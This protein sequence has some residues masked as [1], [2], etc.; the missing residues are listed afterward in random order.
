MPFCLDLVRA[1]SAEHRPQNIPCVK[2]PE[3]FSVSLGT[4]LV[5]HGGKVLEDTNLC[6]FRLSCGLR[7]AEDKVGRLSSSLGLALCQEMR[8]TVSLGEVGL[9]TGPP[10]VPCCACEAVTSV[11]LFVASL[12][13]SS[14]SPRQDL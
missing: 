13:G 2:L 12:S 3:L 1:V 5:L 6:A 14:G 11:Q 7:Q 8:W 4:E 10:G 9:L